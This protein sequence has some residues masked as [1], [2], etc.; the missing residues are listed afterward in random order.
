MIKRFKYKIPLLESDTSAGASAERKELNLQQLEEAIM[1]EQFI[2][3]HETYRRDHWE[4]LKH[5]RSKY[6]SEYPLSESIMTH[7][8][9]V[10]KRKDMDKLALN[11]IR[12]CIID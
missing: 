9:L 1:K 10:N 12:Q 2:I 5:F 7:S 11:A 4:A 8:A 6:D 3:D